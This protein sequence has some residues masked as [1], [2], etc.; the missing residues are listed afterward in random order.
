MKACA[1]F[2]RYWISVIP[3]ALSDVNSLLNDGV[4]ALGDFDLPDDTSLSSRAS[5][6]FFDSE[7]PMLGLETTFASNAVAHLLSGQS[8][9]RNGFP[10]RRIFNLR[11][12]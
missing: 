10:S 8:S 12:F 6:R 1:V 7:E 3:G 4:A 2:M 5:S 11:P 9:K